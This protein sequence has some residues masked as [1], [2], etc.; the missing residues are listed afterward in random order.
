M[1]SLPTLLGWISLFALSISVGWYVTQPTAT[2]SPSNTAALLAKAKPLYVNHCARCHGADG[3]G[4]PAMMVALKPPPRDFRERPWKHPITAAS[5]RDVILNGIPETAMAPYRGIIS[6]EQADLLA[7]YVLQLSEQEAERETEHQAEASLFQWHETPKV[8]PD[9]ELIDA[10]GKRLRLADAGQTP[11]L[12][13][14]WGTTCVH[15]LAEMAKMQSEAGAEPQS[16]LRI[17]SI[18]VDATQASEAAELVEQ[19]A[20]GHAV[21]VDSSGLVGQ[22][23]GVSALPAYRVVNEGKIL[24]SHVGTLPWDQIDLRKLRDRAKRFGYGP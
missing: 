17:I 9:A 18:C 6:T 15:C 7:S 11:L 4:D 2:E 19:F 3:H 10:D 1:K 12:I 22:R 14:F 8:L 16:P 20:P 21:Y 5:I 23:F 13:H 24:A